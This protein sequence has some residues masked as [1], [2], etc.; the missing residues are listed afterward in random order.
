MGAKVLSHPAVVG[1]AEEAGLR[2]SE[3]DQGKVW[4]GAED[5]RDQS[6]TPILA[7]TLEPREDR[8]GE[9]GEDVQNQVFN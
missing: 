4:A 5:H 6:S 3:V 2:T 1:E 7:D 9:S 8:R